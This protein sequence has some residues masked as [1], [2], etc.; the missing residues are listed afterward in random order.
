MRRRGGDVAGRPVAERADETDRGA[1]SG[2]RAT[3]WR[4]ILGALLVTLLLGPL[5]PVVG[6]PTPAAAADLVVEQTRTNADWD[7]VG[8]LGT[9][10]AIDGNVLAVTA[11]IGTVS[12]QVRIYTRADATGPWTLSDTVE[13]IGGTSVG[14][15]RAVALDHPN[16]AVSDNDSVHWYVDDPVDGFVEQGAPL[17]VDGV[18]FGASLA[19]DS[20]GDLL[21]GAPLAIPEQIQTG[22]VYP[23]VL[24]PNGPTVDP[25]SILLAD[26]AGGAEGDRFGSSIAVTSETDLA[27]ATTSLAWIGAPGVDN[28]NQADTGQVYLFTAGGTG[29]ADTGPHLT[30]FGAGDEA[31]TIVAADPLN[32]R[33]VIVPAVNAATILVHVDNEQLGTR[34][35]R[36]SDVI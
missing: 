26:Y 27:G 5:S 21:V 9:A 17:T 1:R 4:R 32:P 8:H 12:S 10:M 28:A 35:Q 23:V 34:T 11:P 19:F 7:A 13:E 33:T 2:H 20:F 3:R 6:G 22:A 24:T 30:Q 36:N 18:D 14:F 15:G 29:W 31:G 25:T 16:L